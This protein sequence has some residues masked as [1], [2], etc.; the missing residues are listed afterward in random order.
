[1]SFNNDHRF[2]ILG[3]RSWGKPKNTAGLCWCA[4]TISKTIIACGIVD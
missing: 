1:M 4:K 3:W 2:H